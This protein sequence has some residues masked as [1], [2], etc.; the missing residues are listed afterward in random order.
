MFDEIAMK[1]ADIAAKC[2]FEHAQEVH[3]QTFHSM[4]E[5]ES[6]LREEVTEAKEDLEI[7]QREMKILF[8]ALRER[9]NMAFLLAMKQIA[10]YAKIGT[11]ELLQVQA[12]CQKAFNSFSNEKEGDSNGQEDDGWC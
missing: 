5:A 6:V 2:E 11:L 8:E 10:E 3:G 4:H 12:V 9:D 7:I 1:M